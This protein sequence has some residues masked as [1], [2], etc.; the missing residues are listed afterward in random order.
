MAT[1]IFRKLMM[2]AYKERRDADLW[3]AGLFE[4]RAKNIS[5]TEKVAID[6]VRWEENISPVV[7]ITAGPT[8]NT[9][10]SF[11]T[12]EWTPPSINEGQPFD[13][14]ELMRRSPGSNEYEAT[15]EGFQ[16]A[17]ADR[18]MEGM[19]K[20]EGK[21]R[22]NRN[23]Q[24]SQ[25]LQTGLLA[26]VDE[27][28]ND[29]YTIDFKPKSSHFPTA[30]TAWDAGSPTPLRDIMDLADVIRDDSGKDANMLIMGD[31]SFQAFIA[32]SDVSDK[33]NNR[34]YEIGEIA[35]RENKGVG[36][37]FQ[38]VIHIGSYAFEIWTYNGRA[39]IPGDS[40]ATR[41]IDRDSCI[42]MSNETRFDTVFAGVP[43]PT[44]TLE[45]FADI[46][47]SRISIPTAVDIAPNIYS[48]TNGK[49]VMLEVESRPLL[50]PTA[51]DAYGNL[52][53]GV[54]P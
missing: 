21:I 49:T 50:I 2:E 23:W 32:S 19:N 13:A 4:T 24:A 30:G 15:D 25:V 27:D 6:V 31:L 37:K 41:M 11:T 26:L 47:P 38:G 22:R 45:R 40:T 7:G 53:T 39:I 54:S 46:L 9:N 43:M 1:E 34:R 36:G 16:E 17:F 20:L 3:L 12:K 44:N 5:D 8:M 10:N 51:I 48:S 18:L 14:A 28:G 42:L 52:N 29:A 35:P 33:L